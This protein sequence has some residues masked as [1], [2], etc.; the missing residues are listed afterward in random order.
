MLNNI[1]PT[2]LYFAAGVA[3]LSLFSLLHQS[4]FSPP[5]NTKNAQTVPSPHEARP[6]L[7]NPDVAESFPYPPAQTKSFKIPGTRDVSTPYGAIR[8]YEFGPCQPTATARRII[9][10]HGISTP[11]IALYPLAWHLAG[12]GC[13]VLLMDLFG[14]GW[15]GGPRDLPYDGRL[16]T[17][18]ILMAL[19]SSEDRAG[20]F[21]EGFV[22]AG[23][24]LGG[25]LAMDFASW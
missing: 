10:L 16:Y 24:S 25:G 14:R 20:W 23:Y 19:A 4:L 8:V 13:R 9:F 3:S 6:R 5:K 21:G 2:I 17:S 12:Q 1:H 18:Q 22:V 11:S 15:S 7:L